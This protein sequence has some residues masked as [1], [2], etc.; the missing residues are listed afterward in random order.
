[1]IIRDCDV[2]CVRRRVV[3]D[4]DLLHKSAIGRR[5]NEN[6]IVKVS[7]RNRN[8]PT[9]GSPIY[10]WPRTCHSADHCD[11][12]AN[13]ALQVLQFWVVEPARL[14]WRGLSLQSTRP[15]VR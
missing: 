10:N 1:M 9:T 15:S 7:L 2:K 6:A 5:T 14:L 4:V 11:G 8:R 13:S 12:R 3:F